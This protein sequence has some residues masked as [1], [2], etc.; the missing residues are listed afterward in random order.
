MKDGIEFARDVARFSDVEAA[1][2]VDVLRGA[3]MVKTADGCEDQ[4]LGDFIAA[5]DE[6]DCIEF[7]EEDEALVDAD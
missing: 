1:Y 7:Y 6:C 2:L 3:Y 5:L 4:L